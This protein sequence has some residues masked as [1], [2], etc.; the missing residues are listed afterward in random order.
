MALLQHLCPHLFR[1]PE[2]YTGSESKTAGRIA[3][4]LYPGKCR[5]TDG[6]FSDANQSRVVLLDEKKEILREWNSYG[7]S[8]SWE[9]TLPYWKIPFQE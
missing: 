5:D 3:E 2:S 9:E 7:G 6:E 8:T 4:G 1:F